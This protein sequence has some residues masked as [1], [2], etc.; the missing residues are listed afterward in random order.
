M[1]SKA[2]CILLMLLAGLAAAAMPASATIARL[3]VAFPAGA[4]QAVAEGRIGGRD[5]ADHVVRARAGQTLAV[6]ME[7]DSGMAYFNVLPPGSDEAIFIGSVSGRP[8][9]GDDGDGA[10]R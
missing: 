8:R 3:P 10:Q 6:G 9:E 1:T 4:T 7:A 5:S 2:G